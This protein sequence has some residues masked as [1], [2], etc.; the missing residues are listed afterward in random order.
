MWTKYERGGLLKS[1]FHCLRVSLYHEVAIIYR[2]SDLNTVASFLMSL[3]GE[4]FSVSRK[5]AELHDEIF[6]TFPLRCFSVSCDRPA[7]PNPLF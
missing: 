1:L 2:L 3:E 6:V 5:V 4:G 7:D